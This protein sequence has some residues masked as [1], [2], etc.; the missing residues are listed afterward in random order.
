MILREATSN[1]LEPLAALCKNV[2]QQLGVSYNTP[3]DR[4]RSLK[5]QGLRSFVLCDGSDMV[6]ALSADE[7]ETHK[8]PGAEVVL[9]VVDHDRPDRLKLLDALCLYSLNAAVAEGRHVIISRDRMH[10]AFVYGR[11]MLGMAEEESAIDAKTGEVVEITQRGDAKVIIEVI[12]KRR[13]G[14]RISL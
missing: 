6:A 9:F 13:P 12:L 10:T 3:L 11:D 4:L 5:D 8:G 7:L 2:W 1:D 14:W